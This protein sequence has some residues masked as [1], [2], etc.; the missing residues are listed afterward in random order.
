M[1]TLRISKP[2]LFHSSPAVTEARQQARCRMFF[3][4]WQHKTARGKSQSFKFASLP[5]SSAEFRLH[6]RR[7]HYQACLWTAALN[8]D[9]PDMNPTDFGWK[10]DPSN[11]IL[12]PVTL[13]TGTL[14]APQQ[15][16]NLLCCNCSSTEACSTR[17]CSCR[18]TELTCSVFCKCSTKSEL[19]CANPLNKTIDDAIDD[20]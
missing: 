19:T 16:L 10:V 11:Q 2:K 4:V 17:R 14:A 18:K 3:S 8:S 20:D 7:A 9:P 15:V 12:L 1:P 13:P 5:P 6:V